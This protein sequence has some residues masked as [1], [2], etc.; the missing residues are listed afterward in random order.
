MSKA[1]TGKKAVTKATKVTA[2]AAP[3]A[4][5]PKAEPVVEVIESVDD[6]IL[7]AEIVFDEPEY[8]IGRFYEVKKSDD[9]VYGE[10][11]EIDGTT[12]TLD[13]W[14]DGKPG[15]EYFVFFEN[16][17][18]REINRELCFDLSHSHLTE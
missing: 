17:D 1:T 10:L 8:V 9:T 18:V 12:K 6:P 4:A 2:K 13:R 14:V 15:Y 3:K 7:D 11:V 5:K 16:W